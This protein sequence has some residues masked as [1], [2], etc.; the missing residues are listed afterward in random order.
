MKIIADE[1]IPLL[2]E[3]FGEMGDL[4]AILGRGITA[5]DVHNADALLV[6]SVTKVNELLVNN[7]TSLKFVATSTSGV[8]HIDQQLLQRLGIS[9]FSAE[10]CNA[11]AVSEYVLSA[12]DILS[13]KYCFNLRD[14]TFGVVGSGQIGSRLVNIFQHIGLRVLVTD[15]L[16]EKAGGVEYVSLEKLIE[17]CDVISL[18]TPLTVDGPFPT[19][20]MIKKHELE[21]MRDGTVLISAGRG[22]VV[23]NLALQQCLKSG[24]DIK[25][26][27]DVWE[28]EPDIDFELLKRV[29]LA[30]PHIAGYSLDSKI[31]GTEMIYKAFCRCFGLPARIRT[32]AITPIPSLRMM[33][34]IENST[35]EE[36]A[37][38]AIRA[39]YDIRR[40]DAWMRQF[41]L[42]DK[43]EA[44]RAFDLMRANYPVRREFSTLR[45]KLKRCSDEA[46]KKIS[47]LGFHVFDE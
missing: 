20:H 11:T 1:N 41:L 22:A 24:K 18:H 3:C 27:M 2:K 12:L 9:F 15:P 28:H 44:K 13:E 32:A 17:C 10:G 5:E 37:S 21:A 36:V 29:D 16:C 19:Y 43:D 14:R 7:N 39:V 30:T 35:V 6:R 45:I 40:D 47:S 46:R 31:A 26:V 33:S 34:F 42:M 38:A 8:D 4:V 25:V 23:D